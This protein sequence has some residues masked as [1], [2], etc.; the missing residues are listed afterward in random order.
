VRVITIADCA[1]LAEDV[2]DP[3]S[4]APG[5]WT[6]IPGLEVGWWHG[7]G[8]FG[9]AYR[10]SKGVV[11]AFR[12]TN[13]ALDV[14]GSWPA[15]GVGAAPA[16]QTDWGVWLARETRRRTGP[17]IALTGHSLGGALAKAVATWVDAPAVAF[18]APGLMS[19]AGPVLAYLGGLGP[20]QPKITNVAAIGDMVSALGP[21]HVNRVR[22]LT[23]EEFASRAC[24]PASGGLGGVVDWHEMK[25]LR[26]SVEAFPDQY[27]GSVD[28]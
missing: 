6:P 18:N 19:E 16:V 28:Y 1:Y 27:S 3:T 15:L 12:G 9:R 24:L 2:Y 11:L 8:F 4:R 25:R 14:I 22:G 5:G 21:G 10:S 23:E 26:R 7:Y 17:G 13:D 20:H